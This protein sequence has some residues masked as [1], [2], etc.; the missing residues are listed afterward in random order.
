MV[1]EQVQEIVPNLVFMK[2]VKKLTDKNE[3]N[4]KYFIFEE[5]TPA[6]DQEK[7][8]IMPIA[9]TEYPT[10]CSKATAMEIGGWLLCF[11]HDM[12]LEWTRENFEYCLS[13]AEAGYGYCQ[14]EV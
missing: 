5:D 14:E 10:I 13:Q 12:N 3:L 8:V 9:V 2:T 1:A 6:L 4:E 11:C 7:S